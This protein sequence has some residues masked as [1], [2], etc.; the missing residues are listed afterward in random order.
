MVL[1][2]RKYQKIKKFRWLLAGSTL[3]KLPPA[4]PI[5]IEMITM[6]TIAIDTITV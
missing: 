1:I 6:V 2:R 3:A 5:S 4:A